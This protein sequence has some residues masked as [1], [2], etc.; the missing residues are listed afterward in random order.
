MPLAPQATLLCLGDS[1]TFGFGAPPEA[2]YPS[3]LATLTGRTSHNAGVNGDTTEG[4]LARLPALL[5]AHTPG[6]VL[7]SIGGNDF[8]RKRPLEETRAALRQIVQAAAVSA[9][10]VLIA[11]PQPAVLAAAVGALHDHPVYAEVATETG[12]ALYPKGWSAVLSRPA[13][14]SDPIHANAEGYR[15]FASALAGWLRE[16][17]FLP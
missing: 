7:V 16:Q 14:R 6:L 11:Q 3:Q 4:A 13:W 17:R 2:S 10:V 15:Q 5:E 12:T 8:L 9:Q 1:L